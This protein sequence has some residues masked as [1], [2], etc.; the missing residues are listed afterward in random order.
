M[1]DMVNNEIK[2]TAIITGANSGIG[3]VVVKTLKDAG[4]RV[5]GLTSEDCDMSDLVATAELADKLREEHL[6]VDA[7]IHVAGIWHSDDEAFVHRDL[8]DYSSAWIAATM[9][10]GVTSFMILTARL[11]PNLAKDGVVIGVSGTFTEGASGW[12][13]Y[14]TS[15]RALED[16]LVGLS[17]DY[18]IGPKVYG[19]SPADTNTAAFAKFFPD[20]AKD[21]QPRNSIS[22]LVEHVVN[23]NSP[24]ETGD[25]IAVKDKTAGKGYH[26]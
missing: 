15:K 19:I 26:A 1:T 20:D 18:P 13:P 12:L 24:Y 25:I 6:K 22:T 10:V 2:K 16:F 23:G 9:N 5:V 4:W 11:L 8:E 7:L 17:Q 14:Y 21:A 3:E